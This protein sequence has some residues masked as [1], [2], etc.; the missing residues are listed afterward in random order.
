MAKTKKSQKKVPVPPVR[1]S[2]LRK[3]SSKVSSDAK[4][5]VPKSIPQKVS[6]V[7]E[8]LQAEV[9]E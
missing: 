4:L 1:K 8:R 7:A 3:P 6:D 2:A 5:L 9:L